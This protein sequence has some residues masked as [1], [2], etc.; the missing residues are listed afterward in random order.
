MAFA[1][2][3][4][5]AVI[6][7]VTFSALLDSASQVLVEIATRSFVPP[8]VS[9]DRLVTD[10]KGSF[11]SKSSRDLLRAPFLSEQFLDESKIAN[12]EL[13]VSSGARSAASSV[14]IGQ[15]GSVGAVAGCTIPLYLPQ[16]R[17]PV[18]I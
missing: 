3:A 5:T 9:V 18:P 10:R 12:T 1:G 17:A 15:L 2:E 16:D 4:S 13:V 14:P 6:A 8:G 11:S 7:V